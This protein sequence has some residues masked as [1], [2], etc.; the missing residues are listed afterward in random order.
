[1]VVS[2]MHDHHPMNYERHVIYEG[3]MCPWS[4]TPPPLFQPLPA[5]NTP[6]CPSFLCSGAQIGDIYKRDLAL[7]H[8]EASLCECEHPHELDHHDPYVSYVGAH[9]YDES[10]YDTGAVHAHREPA[11][12]MGTAHAYGEPT[13]DMGTAHAY[14]EP[15]YETGVSLECQDCYSDPQQTEYYRSAEY[16]PPL[17]LY[18]RY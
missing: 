15:T 6:H 4:T 14:G 3:E 5:Q 18:R 7:E 9:A 16:F 11:H 17:P 2:E 8:H 10:A 13:Y 12:D 1:M